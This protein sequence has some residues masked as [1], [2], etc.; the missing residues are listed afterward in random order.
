MASELFTAMK[1]LFAQV[2]EGEKNASDVMKSL[3]QWAREIGDII[4]DKVAEEVETSVAKM[5]FIKKEEFTALE[6][7]V[8]ELEKGQGKV[9]SL[10]KAPSHKVASKSGKGTAKRTIKKKT[11]KKGRP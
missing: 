2:Q 9:A 8:K 7:R 6:R 11:M 5:G 10:K 4:K 3:N 1:V